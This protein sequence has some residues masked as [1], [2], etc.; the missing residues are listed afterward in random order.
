VIKRW[1][2]GV[3]PTIPEVTTAHPFKC[4]P[5]GHYKN[6]LSKSESTF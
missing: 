1:L 4:R 2:A 6:N 5:S 3:F